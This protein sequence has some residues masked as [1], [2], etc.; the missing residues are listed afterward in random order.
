MCLCMCVCARAHACLCFAELYSQAPHALA[1]ARVGWKMEWHGRWNGWRTQDGHARLRCDSTSVAAA[2]H[3]T[4]PGLFCRCPGSSATG[5][6]ASLPL[7]LPLPLA[8]AA[9]PLGPAPSPRPASLGL[10]IRIRSDIENGFRHS[11]HLQSTTFQQPTGKAHIGA[12]DTCAHRDSEEKQTAM[13]LRTW[14]PEHSGGCPC[15][16]GFCCA[17]TLPSERCSP[18]GACT[19]TRFQN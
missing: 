1:W 16:A 13:A 10:M 14:L 5:S 2:H 7:P 12:Y 4:C 9:P 8:P 11:G 6:A 3:S 18:G 17:R 15:G 19:H